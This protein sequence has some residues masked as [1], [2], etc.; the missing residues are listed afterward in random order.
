MPFIP[1]AQPSRW[2]SSGDMVGRLSK[3][4]SAPRVQ[5]SKLCCCKKRRVNRHKLHALLLPA[6]R[7]PATPK[8][9]LCGLGELTGARFVATIIPGLSGSELGACVTNSELRGGVG[10]SGAARDGTISHS[11]SP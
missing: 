7:P 10:A 6:L 3:S 11:R 2:R 9:G 5:E 4:I 8:A 1:T